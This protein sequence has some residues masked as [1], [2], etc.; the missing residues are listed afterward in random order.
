MSHSHCILLFFQSN[1]ADAGGVA[2]DEHVDMTGDL[3]MTVVPDTIPDPLIG[4]DAAEKVAGNEETEE[5]TEL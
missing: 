2:T 5:S 3:G 4:G 1:G